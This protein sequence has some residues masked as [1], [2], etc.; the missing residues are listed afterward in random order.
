M[1]MT[2]GTVVLEFAEAA[3]DTFAAAFG[4]K[5]NTGE[6]RPTTGPEMVIALAKV[7]EWVAFKFLIATFLLGLANANPTFKQL[8]EAVGR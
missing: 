3:Q 1:G 8:I 2:T 4:L 5:I 6:R 7:V